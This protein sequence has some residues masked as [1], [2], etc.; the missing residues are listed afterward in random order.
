MFIF[1]LI[2][3]ILEKYENNLDFKKERLYNTNISSIH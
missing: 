3:S 2:Y 1:E